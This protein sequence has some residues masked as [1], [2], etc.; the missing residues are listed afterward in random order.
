VIYDNCTVI[1]VD[2]GRRI[3]T[4]AAVAVE[5]DSIAMVGKSGL[6]RAAYPAAPVRDLHGWLLLPGLVDGH[7]HLPQAM[8]RGSGDEVPLWI[9]MAKRIFIL[10]GN[11]TPADVRASTRLAIVEMIKAGTTAF[12]ETLILGRHDLSSLAG[13]ISETGIRAVLPRAVTDGGGYLDESP[14]H[15]GLDE[16]PEEAIADALAVAK[17]LG[18]SELVRVWLGPRSTGGVTEGLLREVVAL[19]RRED[20]GLCQHYAMTDREQAY[21][22]ERFGAGQVEF[23]ERIE[24][25]G[26]DVVLVHCCVLDADDIGRLS[27]TGTSIVHCPTGPAKMG[28]GVTPVRALLDAGVNVALGTDAAA[29]NNG[30]DLLRDLK[31]VAYLQKLIEREPTVVTAEN[32]LEMATIGGAKALGIDDLIGSIEAGKRA[33]FIVVSTDGPHW[34]PTF[35]P[36]ANFVYAG[37]G[38]DVDTVVVAGRVLMEGRV[39]TTLDEERVLA[40]ARAAVDDLYTRTGVERP[41]VWPVS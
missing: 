9:W 8:L 30:A 23:L 28:S 18:D 34:V 20:M 5:G 13:M 1:T 3:I 2:R 29:A 24:M 26:K 41:A 25:V 40:E 21:I 10:E 12:L 19:A 6:V 14:L 17:E 33:D 4:G 22:R 36:V 37:T 39:L 27:G 11:Y 16:A 32:V 35:N 31:W 15:P 7:V 38:A